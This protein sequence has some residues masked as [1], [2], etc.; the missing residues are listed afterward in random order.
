MSSFFFF[1]LQILLGQITFRVL[2]LILF[3]PI[4][5]VVVQSFSHV[6]LFVT[7]WTTAHQSS[8]S[9]TISQGLLKLMS[10]EL[11][12]PSNHLILCHPF[13]L[14]SVFPSI[15]TFCKWVSSSHKV[16]KGLEL[17]LQHQSFQWIFR[18]HF[19]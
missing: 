1:F 19:L 17:H 10:I 4:G 9:F 18:V 11:V 13:L 8:L 16:A 12:R 15:S 5:S 3:N 14:P 7:P 6:W 2:M